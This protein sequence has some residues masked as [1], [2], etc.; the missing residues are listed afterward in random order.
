MSTVTVLDTILHMYHSRAPEIPLLDV[1]RFVLHSFLCFFCLPFFVCWFFY[2]IDMVLRVC[3]R[4]ISMK[5]PLVSF[6]PLLA[7]VLSLQKTTKTY[8]FTQNSRAESCRLLTVTMFSP[9]SWSLC[10]C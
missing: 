9:H 2:V 8:V 5:V 4:F 7:L 6:V 1:G 3:F 10:I